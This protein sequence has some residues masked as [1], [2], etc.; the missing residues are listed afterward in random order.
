VFETL[1]GHHRF[2]RRGRKAEL[3]QVFVPDA[4]D[5]DRAAR[6]FGGDI[7]TP[8]QARKTVEQII[9]QRRDL[10]CHING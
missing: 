4:A 1:E 5:I 3:G 6:G 9:E 7:F 2:K 8:D 10:F